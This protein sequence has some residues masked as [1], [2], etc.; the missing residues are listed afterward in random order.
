MGIQARITARNP[1]PSFME[2][3]DFAVP[4]RLT[5]NIDSR[6]ISLAKS[7]RRLTLWQSKL[8]GWIGRLPKPLAFGE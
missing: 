4:F 8:V 5:V 6:R 1:P 7:C 2:K 3:T